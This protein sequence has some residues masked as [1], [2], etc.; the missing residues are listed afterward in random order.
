MK[1]TYQHSNTIIL[2]KSKFYLVGI[3]SIKTI[4]RALSTSSVGILRAESYFG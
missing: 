1:P 4:D 3:V 2:Q